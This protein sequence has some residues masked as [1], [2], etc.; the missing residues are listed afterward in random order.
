MPS[1]FDSQR[2][3]RELDKIGVPHQQDERVAAVSRLLRLKTFATRSLLYS[4]VVPPKD[5]LAR[6]A[7]ELEVDPEWLVGK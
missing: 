1:S 7:S 3:H 6:A 5:V 4:R 2:L